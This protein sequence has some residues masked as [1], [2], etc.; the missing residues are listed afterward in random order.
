MKVHFYLVIGKR[1]PGLQAFFE[2]ASDE[3]GVSRWL[4]GPGT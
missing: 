1:F 2:E 3:A 4:D